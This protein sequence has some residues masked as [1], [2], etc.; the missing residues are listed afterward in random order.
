[1]K[2]L[3]PAVAALVLLLGASGA[4]PV[5]FGGTVHDS[6]RFERRFADSLR[7]VLEP[8]DEGWTIRIRGAD[9][10]TDFAGIVTPPFHGP[11]PLGIQA[12]H[13]RNAD[14]TGPIVANPTS[15]RRR[16]VTDLRARA[17]GPGPVVR[18]RSRGAR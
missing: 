8:D 11:N 3:V 10:L 2:R 1:M 17:S 12:W 5:R 16:L 13:F 14:N 4:A 15:S 6:E 9:T 18:R 7:L